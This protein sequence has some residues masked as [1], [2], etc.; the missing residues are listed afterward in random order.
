MWEQR[1]AP[2]AL[3]VG[4]AASEL[5]P[6]GLLYDRRFVI[7]DEAGRFVTQR[8]EHRLALSTCCQAGGTSH[9]TSA[10]GLLAGSRCAV[11][12]AP[13]TTAGGVLD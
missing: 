12:A 9:P 8:E 7:A 13:E 10:R 3:V 1:R 6:R 11:P 5:G 2:A 4:V